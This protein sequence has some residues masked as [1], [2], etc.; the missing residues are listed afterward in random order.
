[1]PVSPELESQSLLHKNRRSGTHSGYV[2]FHWC[3]NGD[4][5]CPKSKDEG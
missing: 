5:H 4:Y 3:L 2:S 1:M